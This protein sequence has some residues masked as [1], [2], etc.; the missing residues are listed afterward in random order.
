MDERLDGSVGKLQLPS[1]RPRVRAGRQELQDL[2]ASGIKD[3]AVTAAE[4]RG[5]DLQ[6]GGSRPER[7]PRAAGWSGPRAA[8]SSSRS[9]PRDPEADVSERLVQASAKCSME[10]PSAGEHLRVVGPPPPRRPGRATGV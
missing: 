10:P 7:S 4:A 6:A 2:D 5:L 3:L 8:T 1:D 9:T